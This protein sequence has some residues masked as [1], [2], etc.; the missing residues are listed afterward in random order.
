MAKRSIELAVEFVVL[1][2]PSCGQLFAPTVD[3]VNRRQQDGALFYCPSGHPQLFSASTKEKLEAAEAENTKLKKS[4]EQT[5]TMLRDVEEWAEEQHRERR[6]VERSL[7]G[8]RGAVTRL[9]K[10][11]A[12]GV[13]PCCRRTFQNLAA[14]ME[15]L[16]PEWEAQELA[17]PE[18][19]PLLALPE[20][21]KA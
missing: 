4:L 7:A 17:L 18:S 10:R 9:K 1:D 3:F 16:H 20:G 11:V 14:H 8:T 2:C 12:H 15:L 6:A 21:E 13:C 5:R 19:V